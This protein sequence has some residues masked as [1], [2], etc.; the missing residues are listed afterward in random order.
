MCL[1]FTWTVHT[2][3]KRWPFNFETIQI[4]RETNTHTKNWYEKLRWKVSMRP[5]YTSDACYPLFIYTSLQKHTP[6]NAFSF[7]EFM[8]ERSFLF[9]ISSLSTVRIF[10]LPSLCCR[11]ENSTWHAKSLF[12]SYLYYNKFL[13]FSCV[14]YRSTVKQ[15]SL[16][17]KVV[18][19]VFSRVTPKKGTCL[20]QFFSRFATKIQWITPRSTFNWK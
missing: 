14:P 13:L 4:G 7:V 15:G 5:S 2:P 16:V 18:S 9:H 17:R 12:W 6:T 20:Y 8:S 11:K 10:F 3:T 1:I 19:G